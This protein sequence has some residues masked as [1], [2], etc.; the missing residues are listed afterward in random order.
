LENVLICL[1]CERQKLQTSG[2]VRKLSMVPKDT[3]PAASR[4][5]RGSAGGIP[6][7][8]PQFHVALQAPRSEY[9]EH[10]IGIEWLIEAFGC[11]EVRLLDRAQLSALFESIVRGMALRPVGDPVWHVFERSGGATGIWLLQESHLTI[12]TFP[13]YR[14]VCVNVF[15]CT[16]REG[17]DW[18]ET[19][20]SS[21]GA[22]DVRVRE[23]E[24]VYHRVEVG[25]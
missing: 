14:S 5:G 3:A 21:L 10:M 24:R 6:S 11:A 1:P 9:T 12:H 23:F 7:T 8:S 17:L 20:R 25:S 4:Q 18:R 13:E 22:T 16:P 15:C 2:Y 19:L